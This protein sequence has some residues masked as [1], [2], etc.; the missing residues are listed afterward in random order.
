MSRY[1]TKKPISKPKIVENHQGGTGYTLSPK[2]ELV[3]ILAND[4]GK[5]YYEK[6]ND[7]EVR[8]SNLIKEISKTDPTFVAKALV[9]TRS[10]IGQRSVTH[11]SAPYLIPYLSGTHLS[12]RI[13]TR[14][15]KNKN[16]GGLIYRLDDMAEIIS[17]YKQINGEKA[18]LPSGLRKGF[19]SVLENATEYE[20]A[21]Y[22]LK[23]KEYSLIDLVRLIRPKPQDKNKEAYRK[24]IEGTLKQFDTVED[25]NV[26]SGQKVAKAVKSGEIS[27]QEGEKILQKEKESNYSELIKERKIGYLALIRN[28]RNIISNTSDTV[29]LNETAKLLVDESMIR[30]SLIFP[31]Q[32]DLAMEILL[33]E[34]V[35]IP[36]KIL[37]ALNE[38]YELSIPNLTELFPDGK[39]A[40]VIDTSGSM[41]GGFG[42]GYIQCEGGTI[43][44]SPLS[45]AG[46]IGA[47]L[48]KGIRADLYQFST[49]CKV[50]KY[51][52][53]DTVNTIK[54]S[55][56][57][58][59]GQ[60][61]YGTYYDSIFKTLKPG[62]YNRIFIISDMQGGDNITRNSSF[63]T[64]KKVNGD[65]HIYTIDIRGYGTTMFKPNSR[66]Y[67]LFGYSK[68]IYELVK[69][70]EVDPKALLNEIESIKI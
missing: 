18:P 23:G 39:T 15:D 11:F 54:Q 7:R 44:K 27:K 4:F 45:K 60:V 24:L 33:L 47:T 43:R 67:Q 6:L 48:V 16:I 38:A 34:G 64:Y 1:N 10:V 50:I 28:L 68:D 40:V 58:S 46:L 52:P 3:G 56:I 59:S 25:K 36:T 35:S 30:K 22:Q 53:L 63:Q 37:Q 29:L 5:T 31:H 57:N 12:S 61:G 41:G 66:L 20:L 21:K 32:I 62:G 13:F 8:L 26:N 42:S 49:T 65:P 17:A 14:R 69:K 55:V 9:Y 2:L 19:K 70:V 51:N